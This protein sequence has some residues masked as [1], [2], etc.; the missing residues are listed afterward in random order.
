MSCVDLTTVKEL[1]GHKS[2]RMT[3]RYAQLATIHKVRVVNAF[4]KNTGT[5]GEGEL[6]M[7][8]EWCGME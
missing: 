4:N 3:Q 5:G 6:S 7:T 1:L 8:R 2:I